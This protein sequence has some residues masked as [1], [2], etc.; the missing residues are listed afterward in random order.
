[1]AN[2]AMADSSRTFRQAQ[3]NHARQ[4]FNYHFLYYINFKFHYDYANHYDVHYDYANHYDYYDYADDHIHYDY[5]NDH[6]DLYNILYDYVHVLYNY[7]GPT[8]A[9]GNHAGHSLRTRDR[10]RVRTQRDLLK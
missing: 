10:A 5:A 9:A 4:N 6:F 7:A 1:M 2:S 3:S 8:P